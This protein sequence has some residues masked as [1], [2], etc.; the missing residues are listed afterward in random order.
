MFEVYI[1]PIQ[2]KKAILTTVNFKISTKGK[3]VLVNITY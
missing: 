3:K 2:I 1:V